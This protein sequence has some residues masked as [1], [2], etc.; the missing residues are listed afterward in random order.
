MSG[1]ILGGFAGRATAGV[2]AAD[3]SWHMSFVVLAVMTLVAALALF[4]LLPEEHRSKRGGGADAG[5]LAAGNRR[6]SRAL[7]HRRLH[8]AGVD[9]QLHRRSD[10]ARPG[11]GGGV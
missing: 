11:A 7:L 4:A 9:E 2:V 5:Q 8:C 1:T 3:V 6:R 10:D